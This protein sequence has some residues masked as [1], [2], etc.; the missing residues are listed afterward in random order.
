MT[1][2]DAVMECANE[3][4]FVSEFNRLTGCKL[5]F[6]DKRSPIEKI[7]DDATGYP[8]PFK[9]NKEDVHK[10]FDFVF[11]YIWLPLIGTEEKV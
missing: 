9:I 6:T 8:Y 7:I 11:E 4:R 2:Q 1:F 3:P 10:F 5:D